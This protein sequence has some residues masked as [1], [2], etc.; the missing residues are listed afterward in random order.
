[1]NEFTEHLVEKA[2]IT[3]DQKDFSYYWVESKEDIEK[4]VDMAVRNCI[5]E[6][7]H[8]STDGEYGHHIQ[9][10][11]VNVVNRIKLKFGLK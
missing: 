7:V 2:G 1:M 5:F 11:T 9:G 4:L 8:E 3:L 10:F 6:L